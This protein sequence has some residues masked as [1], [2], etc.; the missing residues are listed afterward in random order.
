[1]SPFDEEYNAWIEEKLPIDLGD[2]NHRAGCD[3]F[4]DGDLDLWWSHRCAIGT[5]APARIDIT[6]GQRH[7]LISRDPLHVEPS[8]LC[9]S[10]GD[11]GFIREGKWVS[12]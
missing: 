3:L 2:D 8:I 12:A 4:E 1:M 11:H 7:S 9:R 6:T 10:C 5:R